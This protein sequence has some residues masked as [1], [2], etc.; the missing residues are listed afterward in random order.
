MS[1]GPA[2]TGVVL[3]AVLVAT[4]QQALDLNAELHWLNSIFVHRV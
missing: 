3:S 2:C 4:I 1:L